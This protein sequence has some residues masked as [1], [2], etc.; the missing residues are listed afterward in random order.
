MN[1]LGKWYQKNYYV[2]LIIPNP[3]KENV[4]Y[5]INSKSIVCK[6]GEYN[7]TLELFEDIDQPQSKCDIGNKYIT[8]TLRK[9]SA[10][11]WDYIS[12]DK[13]YKK[14]ITLDWNMYEYSDDDEPLDIN[15]LKD[16][17]DNMSPEEMSALGNMDD[18]SDDNVNELV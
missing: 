15:N 12:T 4:Y 13:M 8:F 17:Y 14:W 16:M 3:N 5:E 6:F 1:P 18:D 9:L 10:G 11:E 7:T 2:Y